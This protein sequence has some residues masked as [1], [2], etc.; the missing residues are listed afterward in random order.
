MC[1]EATVLRLS[2][3]LGFGR[4]NNIGIKYAFEQ[5]ADHI[6]L[7]NQDAYVQPDA[8]E[9]LVDLQR[10]TPE[11][12]ILSPLHLDGTGNNLD[13]RFLYHITKSA[14]G[15]QLFSDLLLGIPREEVYSVEFVNAAIWLLSRNCI[16]KVGLFNPAFE[17]FGEDMEYADRVRFFGFQIGI[18]PSLKA[19]HARNQESSKSTT[20]IKRY[21]LETKAM[22]RYRL[23]R[24]T[25]G[26]LFNILSALSVALFTAPP[27][28]TTRFYQARIKVAYL[29]ILVN[30]LQT[31]LR[32]KR[33]A[34]QGGQCFFQFADSDEKKYSL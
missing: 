7:L 15:R 6:L 23:S 17:H 34:Y 11:Y 21:E 29:F 9:K 20:S 4:A 19:F 3:N 26:T 16:E 18:A 32:M 10:S 25:P 1:P 12:A 28:I 30:S 31:V 2:Q 14:G 5:G 33:V 13:K 27:K 22:I 8:I 24:K